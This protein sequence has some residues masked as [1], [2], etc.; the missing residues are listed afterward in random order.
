MMMMMFRVDSGGYDSIQGDTVSMC[1]MLQC[2]EVRDGMEWDVVGRIG[3][4]GNS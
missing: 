4:N 1:N 3:L 2:A